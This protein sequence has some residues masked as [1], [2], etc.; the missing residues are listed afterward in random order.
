MRHLLAFA[1]L[2][3]HSHN[4]PDRWIGADKI[5]HFL[6]SAMVESLTTSA[7]RS[8]G[9]G[10]ATSQRIGAGITMTVGVG[11]ELHD[12]RVGKGASVKDLTWDAAGGVAA[13]SLLNGAR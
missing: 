9:A 3:Q 11:R 2:A 8:A 1:L 7:A 4:P 5:K 12:A 10:R 13:A 6:L